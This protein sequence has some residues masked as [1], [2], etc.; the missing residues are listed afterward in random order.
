ME[1][2]LSAASQN[3]AFGAAL[4]PKVVNDNFVQSILKK[5]T[6]NIKKY[7]SKCPGWQTKMRYT[8]MIRLKIPRLYHP[9]ES[10]AQTAW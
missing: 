9:T 1:G 5:S 7:L 10:L 8:Q 2:K 6:A 3:F 4:I